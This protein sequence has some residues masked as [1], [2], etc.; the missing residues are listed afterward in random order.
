MKKSVFRVTKQ[1]RKVYGMHTL[2][3]EPSEAIAD[4]FLR[5]EF[6][7][8][9]EAEAL[10]NYH[11]HSGV[12]EDVRGYTKVKEISLERLDYDSKGKPFAVEI[13]DSFYTVLG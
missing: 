1:P 8:Y 2:P 13:F 12:I 9:C 7:H 5:F 4:E 6:T 10:F 3:T 11:K